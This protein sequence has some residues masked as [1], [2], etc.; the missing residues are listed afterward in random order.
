MEHMFLRLSTHDAV[1]PTH[2]RLDRHFFLIIYYILSTMA[3]TLT[4]IYVASIAVLI[5]LVIY[6]LRQKRDE[7]L[8]RYEGGKE[9]VRPNMKPASGPFTSKCRNCRGSTDPGN[10]HIICECQEPWKTTRLDGLRKCTKYVNGSPQLEFV[11]GNL[12]CER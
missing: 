10:A 6:L 7:E 3:N 1:M 12:R 5:L 8:E 11:N 4:I 9:P 2:Q